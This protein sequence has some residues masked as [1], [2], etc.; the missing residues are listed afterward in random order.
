MKLTI[1]IPCYNEG[2]SIEEV[3]RQIQA[4]ELP[5]EREVIVVD[6]GSTDN[7]VE[8]IRKFEDVRLLKH[9]IIHS[10]NGIY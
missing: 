1:V 7:S 3:L 10:Y 6:D 9:E 4:V 8:I 2:E 5:V